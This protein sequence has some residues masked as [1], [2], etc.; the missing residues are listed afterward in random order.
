M[1]K[2]TLCFG[3]L[4]KCNQLFYGA[5]SIHYY[6]K[7]NQLETHGKAQQVARPAQTRL[8]NAVLCRNI[9]ARKFTKFSSDVDGSLAVLTCTSMLRSSHPFWNASKQNEGG[10]CQFSPICAKIGYHSNVPWAIANRR[11]DW[12]CPSTWVPILKMWWRSVQ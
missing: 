9:Q 2:F 8:Q 12:S 6:Q 11:S 5:Q 4:P 3:S 7:L 1:K 10:A